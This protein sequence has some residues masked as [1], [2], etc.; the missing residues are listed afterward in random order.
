MSEWA[1]CVRTGKPPFAVPERITTPT[2]SIRLE[3]DTYA[4]AAS[5]DRY[6]ELFIDPAA[7]T[8]WEYRKVAVPEGGST[9]HIHWVRTPEPVADRVVAWWDAA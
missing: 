9:H 7:L 5:N 2:L 1:R 4:V 6:V 3:G 8:D